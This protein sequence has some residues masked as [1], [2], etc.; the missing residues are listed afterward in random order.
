MPD[1]ADPPRKNY[2]FKEREFKRDNPL[3]SEAAPMPTAKELAMMA[4]PVAQHGKAAAGAQKADDPNDVYAVLQGN[5][6]VEKQL[7]LNEVEIRQI[8]NRRKRDYWLIMLTVEPTLGLIAYLGRGNPFVLACS[9]AGMGFLALG[10]TWIM[11]QV[12]SKY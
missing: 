4:G 2:G 7:G 11:W 3:P 10:F 8:K 9:V 1:E 6:T 12:M 5:R